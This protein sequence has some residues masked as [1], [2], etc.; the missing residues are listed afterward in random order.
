MPEIT[1]V[2]GIRYGLG[3]ISYIGTMALLTL[4]GGGL[5]GYLFTKEAFLPMLVVGVITFFLVLAGMMGLIYK[6]IVDGVER[7][8]LH[9][10]ITMNNAGQD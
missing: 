3:M 4:I 8:M 1:E 7:G 5:T 10:E 6:V 9:A 2:D